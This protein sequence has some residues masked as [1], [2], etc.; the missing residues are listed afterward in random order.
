MKRANEMKKGF[1]ITELMLGV[2]AF[3]VMS[4]A[5][6]SVLV[7]TW[8]NWVH[9]RESIAMQRDATLTM[10]VMA[11]EIRRTPRSSGS[12]YIDDGNMLTCA[13]TNGIHIFSRVGNNLELQ[14]SSGESLTLAQNNCTSFDTFFSNGAVVVE[15]DLNTGTDLSHNRMMIY[16]RN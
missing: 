9:N 1:T 6:G 4:T 11:R 13:N 3:S 12:Y 7:S 8:Q 5:V 2:I 15:F 16:P 14:K 10:H